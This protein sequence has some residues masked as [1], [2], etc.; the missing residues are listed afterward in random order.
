MPRSRMAPIMVG[1]TGSLNSAFLADK[2]GIDS[3]LAGTEQVGPLRSEVISVS[4]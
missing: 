2:S 1:R 3:A 4:A